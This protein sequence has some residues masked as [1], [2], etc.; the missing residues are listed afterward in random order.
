MTAQAQNPVANSTEGLDFRNKSFYDAD[1][2][3]RDLRKADFRGATLHNCSF[4]NSDLSYADF[5]SAD[6]YKSTFR[7]VKL[8][9]VNF[10]HANLCS[11]VMDPRDLYGTTITIHCNSVQQVRMGR[12]WVAGWLQYLLMADIDEQ[13]KAE[14]RAIAEKQVGAE[15]FKVMQKIFCSR[16]GI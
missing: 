2:S 14:I 4:D 8:R 12:M 10:A 3:K 7:M 15:R 16:D 11:T 13:T 6:C 1:F 5:S 9:C